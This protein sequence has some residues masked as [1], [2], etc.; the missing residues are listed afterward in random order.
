MTKWGASKPL[1]NATIMSSDDKQVVDPMRRTKIGWIPTENFE[2]LYDRVYA[3]TVNTNYWGYELCGF[4]EAMQFGVY[5]AKESPAYYK[6]HV[7]IG[8]S[9]NFRKISMIICLSD[10]KE[11]EGGDIHLQGAGVLARLNKG[12][13]IVFPSF[14]H[15]EVTPVTSGIRKSIVAW[16]SGPKLR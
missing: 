7:D 1:S 3:S 9:H 15:H 13:A 11:Y 2:W 6:S 16:I 5:D 12:D 14:L 8:P 10:T 4:A